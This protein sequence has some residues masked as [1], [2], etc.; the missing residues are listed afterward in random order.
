MLSFYSTPQLV[1]NAVTDDT[2]IQTS[3][4]YSYIKQKCWTSYRPHRRKWESLVRLCRCCWSWCHCRGHSCSSFCCPL[5]CKL[6]KEALQKRR[7]LTSS[8]YQKT[9]EEFVGTA[10][11][12][13]SGFFASW[14]SLIFV[15]RNTPAAVTSSQIMWIISKMEG[16]NISD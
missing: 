1:G 11:S 8:N 6:Y 9:T 16:N 10:N 13:F 7:Q 4:T 15:H 3:N 5:S 14:I 12:F 2:F